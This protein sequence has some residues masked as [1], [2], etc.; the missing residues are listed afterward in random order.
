MGLCDTDVPTEEYCVYIHSLI[1]TVVF[2]CPID[3][4][5]YISNST[6]AMMNTDTVVYFKSIPHTLYCCCKHLQPA[7]N[8]R[9][10]IVHNKLTV[11]SCLRSKTFAVHRC[12]RELLRL[13]EIKTVFVSCRKQVLKARA[14]A[15]IGAN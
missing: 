13:F 6:F 5:S 4:H 15:M 12:F 1:C 11:P 3:L 2:L 14:V 8:V 9:L 10:K 7:H